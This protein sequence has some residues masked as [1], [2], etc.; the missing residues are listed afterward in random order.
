P[1]R[2]SI[3][4]SQAPPA[5]GGDVPRSYPTLVSTVV[6]LWGDVT[7][8]HVGAD[9]LIGQ[10]ALR[11]GERKQGTP[12]LL[13]PRERQLAPQGIAHDLA[14]APAELAAQTVELALELGVE[15]D[16]NGGGLHVRQ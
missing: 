2:T 8:R 14:A 7:S 12:R 9:V 11:L 6:V 3:S 16:S 5:W 10:V 1:P 4:S 15:A 13:K